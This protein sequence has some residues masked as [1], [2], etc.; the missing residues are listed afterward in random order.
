RSGEARMWIGYHRSH[1]ASVVAIDAAGRPLH[2]ISEE[3]LSRVKM[4]GSWPKRAAAW[5]EAQLDTQGAQLV[6]G[7]LPLA[8]RLP[9]ELSLAFWN[10]THGQLQDVHPN[11]FA[12]SA[13]H[14]V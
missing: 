8:Q 7:G 1:E 2:A 14:A 11:R 10:A 9:R 12:N 13:A 3:R 6:H 4:Q 5:L